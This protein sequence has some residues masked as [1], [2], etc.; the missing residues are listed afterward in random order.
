MVNQPPH[1]RVSNAK[2]EERRANW[3]C[4]LCDEKFTFGH[5]CSGK[6]LYSLALE[7]A[8]EGEKVEESTLLEP[9]EGDVAELSLHALHGLE[10][11]LENQTMK[12][13]GYYKKRRLNI[14][15]D[16]KSTHNFL[17]LAVAKQLGCS[18]QRVITQRVMVANDNHME[19]IARIKGFVWTMQGKQFEA[20]VLLMPL[21]GSELIIGVEWL[22]AMGS[23]PGIS[24][25]EL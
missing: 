11:S 13:I 24:R 8:E 20:N 6:R 3:F 14:L 19:C 9:E 22:N 2:I 4:F 21:N 5:K 12:L 7:P 17:D 1:K 25:T 23:S 16:S 15:I 10:M 18:L